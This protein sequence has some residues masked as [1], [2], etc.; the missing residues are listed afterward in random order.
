[1]LLGLVSGVD[2]RAVFAAP[3]KAPGEARI[4]VGL[5]LI[6][7]ERFGSFLAGLQPVVLLSVYGKYHLK[8]YDK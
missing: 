6:V 2:F 1:M 4:P 5:D 8:I 7:D 3:A